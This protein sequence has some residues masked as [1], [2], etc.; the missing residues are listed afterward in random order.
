MWCKKNRWGLRRKDKRGFTLL[1]I[2]VAVTILGFGLLA[3]GT[4]EGLSVTNSR[5]GRDISLATAA[6]EEIVELMRR[7]Y[8]NRSSYGG[9]DTTN[10]A[11]RPSAVGTLRNDYDSWKIQIE[12]I[13]PY[14]LQ[15][16]RGT[17]TVIPGPLPSVQQ[18][19]VTVSWTGTLAQS[20]TIQ[21]LL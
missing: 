12:R 16:G 10:A 14:G 15:G 3:V 21:T 17:V 1:E 4:G 20:V 6:A 9:F 5:S 18:I 8:A 7:N 13:L 2:L 11:T 19:T